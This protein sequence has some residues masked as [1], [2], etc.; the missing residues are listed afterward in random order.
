MKLYNA[1]D[2]AHFCIP[3]FSVLVVM[4]TGLNFC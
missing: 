1:D 3:Q 4:E 2:D